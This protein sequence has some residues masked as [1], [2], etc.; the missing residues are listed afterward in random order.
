MGGRWEE[1]E[2]NKEG[3]VSADGLWNRRS[4]SQAV[5]F[6]QLCLAAVVSC[7]SLSLQSDTHLK[8]QWAAAQT[9]LH[10]EHVFGR[11]WEAQSAGISLYRS[12]LIMFGWYGGIKSALILF[13]TEELLTVARLTKEIPWFIFGRRKR[14]DIFSSSQLFIQRYNALNSLLLLNGMLTF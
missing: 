14:R 5:L 10:P 11:Q 2:L 1:P 9:R 6:A 7:R 3:I 8:G 4:G 13:W 12:S